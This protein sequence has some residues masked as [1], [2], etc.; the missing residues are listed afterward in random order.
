MIK[1]ISLRLRSIEV[2]R[3]ARDS[4]ARLAEEDRL[5]RCAKLAGVKALIAVREAFNAQEKADASFM[6]IYDRKRWQERRTYVEAE[7][8]RMVGR[9]A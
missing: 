8:K 3:K 5:R 2:L 1:P 4:S 6:S 7:L 9:T